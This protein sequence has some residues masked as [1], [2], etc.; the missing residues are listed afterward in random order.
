MVI[1]Q[2][3]AQRDAGQLLFA[4][5]EFRTE[6]TKQPS[7]ERRTILEAGRPIAAR[8]A[9]AADNE[10]LVGDVAGLMVESGLYLLECARP[11]VA[12]AD[13][14][15]H[16]LP[17]DM[18]DPNARMGP[19]M[20]AE[21]L[22][23]GLMLMTRGYA[24]A[25][26]NDPNNAQLDSLRDYIIDSAK[27]LLVGKGEIESDRD[28]LVLLCTITRALGDVR[29]FTQAMVELSALLR[30]A[31]QPAA[32][33]AVLREGLDWQLLG[34]EQRNS[35]LGELASALSEQSRFPE[36]EAIQREILGE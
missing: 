18:Q 36:A 13:V 29:L 3:D 27:G 4:L 25:R 20:F 33:E 8:A 26:E 2:F 15:R 5:Q 16:M 30:K 17:A 21:E 14:P 6:S 24:H 12:E 32:A 22:S 35:L 28:R 1:E 23:E 10:A 34:Q 11:T 9:E 31:Q 7:A 19:S